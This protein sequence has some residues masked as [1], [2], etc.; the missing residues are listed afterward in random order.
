MVHRYNGIVVVGIIFT[1]VGLCTGG[2]NKHGYWGMVDMA[3][4]I[5]V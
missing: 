4:T 1:L 5:K 2:G 3:M